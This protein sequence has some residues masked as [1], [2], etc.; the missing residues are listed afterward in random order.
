VVRDFLC[1]FIAGASLMIL[2]FGVHINLTVKPE[3]PT[4]PPAP[5]E[6]QAEETPGESHHWNPGPEYHVKADPSSGLSDAPWLYVPN[7]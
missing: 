4:P 2:L 5:A 1:G 7:N 6:S 3:Q